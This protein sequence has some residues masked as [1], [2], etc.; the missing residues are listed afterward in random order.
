[1]SGKV[2]ANDVEIACNYAAYFMTETAY[3]AAYMPTRNNNLGVK[4]Y[5]R[6]SIHHG[7]TVFS[8]RLGDTY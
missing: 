5:Y 2:N 7:V 4:D 6:N 8:D 1:M 3:G